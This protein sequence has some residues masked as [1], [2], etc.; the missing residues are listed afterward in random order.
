MSINLQSI[1]KVCPDVSQKSH[2]CAAHAKSSEVVT[3][4]Y[5]AKFAC[6]CH[7]A[8]CRHCSGHFCEDCAFKLYDKNDTSAC[9]R[10]A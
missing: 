3:C 4:D 10:C 8:Q 5:C 7:A 9:I 2:V 6:G 1:G